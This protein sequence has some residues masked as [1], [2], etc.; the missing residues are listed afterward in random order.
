M[1]KLAK[2]IAFTSIVLLISMPSQIVARQ[3]SLVK[4]LKRNTSFKKIRFEKD[5]DLDLF[6]ANEDQNSLKKALNKAGYEASFMRGKEDAARKH[7]GIHW[8][9]GGFGAGA[10]FNLL[11]IIVITAAAGGTAPE[12]IPQDVVA[13]AYLK[14]YMNKSES[15]NRTNAFCGSLTSTII[16]AI[17]GYSLLYS[18][19]D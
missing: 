8:F 17:I 13:E 4:L 19:G 2:T 11:G 12:R 15:K 16:V 9:L 5:I 3:I 18:V 10:L 1:N 14:G 6:A 7:S